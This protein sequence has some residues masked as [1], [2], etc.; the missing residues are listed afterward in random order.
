MLASRLWQAFSSYSTFVQQ[1]AASLQ[2]VETSLQFPN[3]AFSQEWK[4]LGPFQ[5]GTRGIKAIHSY[6][7]LWNLVNASEQKQ[8]G[9]QI[10]WNTTAAFEPLSTTRL[11][12][13][14]AH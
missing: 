11:Q 10:P 8:R 9:A 2:E 7:E 6:E 12:H 4:V 14:Q 13:S 3:V 5:I 1:P